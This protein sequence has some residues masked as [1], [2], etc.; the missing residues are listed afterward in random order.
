MD[1]DANTRPTFAI[2]KF[3]RNSSTLNRIH[4]ILSVKP[5]VN[6]TF[7]TG[8]STT[9]RV[10]SSGPTSTGRSPV[11]LTCGDANC[12]LWL[13]VPK[14]SPSFTTRSYTCSLIRAMYCFFI[15]NLLRFGPKGGCSHLPTQVLRSRIFLP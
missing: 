4:A 13:L 1:S 8:I 15:P 2:G 6:H 7:L 14:R 11:D 5:I 10:V 3:Q 9:A 12:F